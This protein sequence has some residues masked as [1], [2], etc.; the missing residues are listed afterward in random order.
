MFGSQDY[1][2]MK[3]STINDTYIH[4]NSHMLQHEYDARKNFMLQIQQQ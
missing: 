2:G 3:I 4:S 1:K